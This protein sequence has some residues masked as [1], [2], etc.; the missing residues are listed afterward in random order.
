M[1]EIVRP[2]QA[3]RT[4]RAMHMLQGDAPIATVTLKLGHSDPITTVKHYAAADTEMKRRLMERV[5]KEIFSDFD[6]DEAV[7][8]GNKDMIGQLYLGKPRNMGI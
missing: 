5:L 4:S 6:I 7:W 3:F 2:H 8:K 1:P